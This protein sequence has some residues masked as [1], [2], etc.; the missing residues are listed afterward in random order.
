MHILIIGAA[1]M[2]G[3]KLTQRLIKDGGLAG[4]AIDKLT[5]VDWVAPTPPTGVPFKVETRDCRPRRRPASPTS[6]SPAGRT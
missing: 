3:A 5:L 2:I 6:S 1:G 4:K